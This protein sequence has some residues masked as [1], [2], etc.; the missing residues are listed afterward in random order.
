ML[1]FSDGYSRFLT[2]SQHINNI[3]IYI[4]TSVAVMLKIFLS[5]VLYLQSVTCI[6]LPRTVLRVFAC[7]K[8]HRA[9]FPK[10]FFVHGKP[11]HRWEDNVRM[12]LK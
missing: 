4:W 9:V 1:V 12:D 8:L 7:L 5:C 3:Y 10:F 2:F 6:N 11:R